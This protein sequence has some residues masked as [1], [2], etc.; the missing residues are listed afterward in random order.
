MANKLPLSMDVRMLPQS[1]SIY[2]CLSTAFI[3]AKEKY[4]SSWLGFW[5]RS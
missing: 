4:F 1:T 2:K 5:L 3:A